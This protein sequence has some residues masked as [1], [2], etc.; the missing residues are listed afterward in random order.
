MIKKGE[1]GRKAKETKKNVLGK[2]SL[3]KKR[4]ETVEWHKTN[5]D[6]KREKKA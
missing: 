6:K 2:N 3:P 5:N 4:R 1:W